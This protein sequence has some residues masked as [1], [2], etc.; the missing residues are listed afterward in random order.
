ML[1]KF[2]ARKRCYSAA[3]SKTAAILHIHKFLLIKR[4]STNEGETWK[5]ITFAQENITIYG[6]ITEPGEKST[7]FTLFGSFAMKSHSWLI[8]QIDTKSALGRSMM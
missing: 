8:I 2:D 3:W 1:C 7:I 5:V 4:Y 6:L